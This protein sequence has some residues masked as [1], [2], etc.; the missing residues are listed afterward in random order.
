MNE[1]SNKVRHILLISLCEPNLEGI[2]V[3]SQF[4]I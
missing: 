4:G 1:T 2:G 3:L